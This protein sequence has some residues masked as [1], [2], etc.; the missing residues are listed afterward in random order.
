MKVIARDVT[1]AL[2]YYT[3]YVSGLTNV[4]RDVAEGLVRRGWKVTV[5]ATQHTADLALEELVNG[6]RV[7]RT[8]VAF[9]L[10][11]GVIS[12]TFIS[13]ICREASKSSILNI[14]TPMLEA[15]FIALKSSVPV[16]MT[17]QCDVSLPPNLTGILQNKIIDF[18][19]QIAARR[20]AFN[21]VS[22]SDYAAHSRVSSALALNQVAISPTCHYRDG[23]Y[24]R[25]RKG[26][27]LHIGFLGRIVEE[28]G[29]EFL[30]KG[31]RAFPELDARLLIA[32]DF[33]EIAGGSVI[34]RVRREIGG[35]P[36]ISMLGFLPENQIADFYA[37]LDVFALPSI[38]PFEAFGIVQ[39]E[40]MMCGVPV[41]ASNLP[42]V[43][44]PIHKTG[45]GIVVEPRSSIGITQAIEQI[46]LKLPG[47]ISGAIRARELYSLDSILDQ[48]ED[49]FERAATRG[50]F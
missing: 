5:V 24:P 31:F 21:V 19:T 10:G 22:T 3:P 2:T 15:G 49:V 8:P 33:S 47:D 1:I 14:H 28:K 37:S 46:A 29:I 44:E 30:V 50:P 7:I 41:I 42:G 11:K 39:V 12:P 48:Y 36:R 18:S 25:F 45:M 4:A 20:T 40:A 13:A 6:V 26:G 23:G 38:N 35:D 34:E 9:R 43:R 16:V 32:G 27:G 17:Y